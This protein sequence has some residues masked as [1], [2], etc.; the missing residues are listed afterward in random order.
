MSIAAMKSESGLVALHQAKGHIAD[1]RRHLT[2]VRRCAMPADQRAL[3]AMALRL[4]NEELELVTIE[5]NWT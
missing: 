4:A 2:T 3:E 5:E 1:A